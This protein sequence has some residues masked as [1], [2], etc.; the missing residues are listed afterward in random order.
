MLSPF[1]MFCK[2]HDLSKSES[3]YL[4]TYLLRYASQNERL[5][6]SVPSQLVLS[7]QNNLFY[8]ILPLLAIQP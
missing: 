7:G 8:I 2:L 3:T 5:V 1:L 4:L 6:H